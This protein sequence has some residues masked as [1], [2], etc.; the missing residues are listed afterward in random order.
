MKKRT[1]VILSLV[2]LAVVGLLVNKNRQKKASRY[3]VGILQT[4]SFPALDAARDGFVAEMKNNF[5]DDVTFVEQNAQ[6]SITQ[7]QAIAASFKAKQRTFDAF[8]AIA[9]PA[10]QALKQQITT[11]PILF[12][13][14]TDPVGL[15]LREPGSNL[16]GSSDM[17]DIHKQI[18][19]LTSLL[20]KVKKVSLLY[21][22]AEPNSALLIKR[23]KSELDLLHI[24]YFE[25][26][27]N[28]EAEVAS[29]TEQATAHGEVVLIPT[30][31]TVSSAFP[32]VKQI[33]DKA[34]VPVIVTWTGEKEAPLMQFG[35]DYTQSGKQAAMLLKA[36]LI[37]HKK[38]SELPVQFPNP[39]VY[40]SAV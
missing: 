17:A 21:N 35:V 29:A 40:V 31:N 6:G 1:I 13:A 23:M 25:A 16:T 19:Y 9:T 4:A 14:V 3:V 7:A 10:V 28:T 39:A 27:A 11:K 8:Y 20:P 32:I 30:D 38:P 15:H 12:A 36:M 5:G 22:P 24:S 2:V 33:C 26:G 37:D 34:R 18:V